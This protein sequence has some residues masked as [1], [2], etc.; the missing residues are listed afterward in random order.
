M[1]AI[2]GLTMFLTVLLICRGIVFQSLAIEN[3]TTALSANYPVVPGKES[4]IC[5]MAEN[6]DNKAHQFKLGTQGL[7]GDFKSWFMQ[8]GRQVDTIELKPSDKCL[9]DLH[10]E[11]PLKIQ[12]EGAT[13]TAELLRDDGDKA[14]IPLS[15]TVSRDYALEISGGAKNLEIMNGKSMSLD[16]AVTNTGNKELKNLLLKVDLPYKWSLDKMTPENLTLQPGQY[17][18]FKMDVS[19]PPSQVSGNFSIK[20]TSSNKVAA[21]NEIII[22]VTVKT[23]MGFAWWMIGLLLAVALATILYFR[24]QGRR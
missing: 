17:A 1:K 21:S 11:A 19:V 20:I 9:I 12:E 4:I 5:I 7:P 6:N 16:I 13:F 8:G 2:K 14:D 15:F 24:R 3:G 10:L 18:L 22:P 23:G